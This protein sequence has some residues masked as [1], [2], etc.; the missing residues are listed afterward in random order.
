MRATGS[1]LRHKNTGD[2]RELSNSHARKPDLQLAGQRYVVAS[3]G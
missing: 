2:Q 1:Q 3:A